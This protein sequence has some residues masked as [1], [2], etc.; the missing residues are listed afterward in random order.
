MRKDAGRTSEIPASAEQVIGE[1]FE[2]KADLADEAGGD[3]LIEVDGDVDGA[4]LAVDGHLIGEIEVGVVDGI[5]AD[6]VLG[7]VGIGERGSDGIGGRVDSAGHLRRHG[8]PLAGRGIEANVAVGGDAHTI[9]DDGDA[10]LMAVGIDVLKGHDVDARRL[11]IFFLIQAEAG[12]LRQQSGDRDS[13]EQE[14]QRG[15]AAARHTKRLGFDHSN[16]FRDSAHGAGPANSYGSIRQDGHKASG[17]PWCAYANKSRPLGRAIGRPSSWAVSSH[18]A[19]TS[20]TLAR[21]SCRVAPSAAQ[22]ANSGT[23]AMNASSSPL[24]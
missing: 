19:I 13:G 9:L 22:P 20:S 15:V 17:S 24:Q 10:A 8:L 7:G 14:R 6:T 11:E 21:A 12:A 18:S 16:Y 4:A 5:E 1:E 2:V 23:S 3:G